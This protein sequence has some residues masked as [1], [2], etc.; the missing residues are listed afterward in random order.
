[1]GRTSCSPRKEP[2]LFYMGSNEGDYR[3]MIDAGNTS[4]KW[5]VFE[6]ETLMEY[7]KCGHEECDLM[8]KSLE[9]RFKFASK[10]ICNVSNVP[11]DLDGDWHIFS[12]HVTPPCHIHYAPPETLGADRIAAVIGALKVSSAHQILVVDLGTCVTYTCAKGDEIIGLCIAPGRIL[13]WKAMHHF[14]AKLPLITPD[15]EIT[16]DFSTRQNLWEGGHEAWLHEVLALSQHYAKRHN[17]V[18]ILFTGS[19]A[20]YLKGFLPKGARI[21][22]RLNLIGLNA[23]LHEK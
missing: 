11:F 14:T 6:T 19:D 7:G 9:S 12:G 22:E 4:V 17:L 18:E 13:R 5:A 15:M 23:W 2:L 20:V 3:L 21:I 16:S 8:I 10:V 1:M